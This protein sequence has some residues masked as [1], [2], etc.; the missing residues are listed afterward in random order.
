IGC[1]F[2]SDLNKEDFNAFQAK[3]TSS[4]PGDRR[5]NIRLPM[6]RNASCRRHTPGAI[7]RWPVEV[8]DESSD[9]LGLLCYLDIEEGARLRIDLPPQGQEPPQTIIVS[10]VQRVREPDGRWLLGC[11]ICPK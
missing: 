11:T 8:R 7:S 2:F 4:A 1:T 9:G 3:G 6:N 5:A 10:V